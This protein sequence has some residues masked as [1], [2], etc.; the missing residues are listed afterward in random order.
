MT[1][2]R[3]HATCNSRSQLLSNKLNAEAVDT[4]NSVAGMRTAVNELRKK[5]IDISKRNRLTNTR[6]HKPRGKQIDIYEERSDEV[7]RILYVNRK[8][9]RF[10]P[11]SVDILDI[12]ETDETDE[13]IFVPSWDEQEPAAHHTDSFL[14]TKFSQE[15]LQKKLLSLYR[16][17]STMEEEQGISVLYLALGFLEWYES[18]SSDRVRHA[19]LVLLPVD[20]ERDSARG[21][22]RLAFRDQDMEP[23][24]S[25]RAMLQ[26]DFG[27]MLPDFPEVDGWLPSEY[28]NPVHGVIS[29]QPRW[30]LL[31][32]TMQ[33]GFYSYA[34]FLMYRDLEDIGEAADASLLNQIL[35]QGFEAGIDALGGTGNLDERFPDPRELGHILDADAS[36]TRIIDAARNGSNLVVQ[37][38]PGTGKS[39]TIANIIAAASKDG[40]RILFVAEKRAALDVVHARLEK[41]DLGPLCLELHSHKVS[42]KHVYAELKRTLELGRPR[43]DNEEQYQRLR[44]VRDRLNATSELL[45]TLDERSGQTPYHVMGTLSLLLSS[46]VPRPDYDIGRAADW[47]KEEF[48]ERLQIVKRLAELTHDLGSERSHLW[49]GVGRRLGPIDR[50]RLKD[51]LGDA[52]EVL[53]TLEVALKAAAAAAGIERISLVSAEE[54]VHAQVVALAERPPDVDGLIRKDV[55]V[56]HPSGLQQLFELVATCQSAKQE[57]LKRVIPGALDLSWQEERLEIAARGRSMFRF[58]SRRYRSAAARLKGASVGS[59]PKSASAR[60][61]LLDKLVEYGSAREKIRRQGALGVAVAGSRWQDEETDIARLLSSTEWICAQ[62]KRTG[63]ARAVRKQIAA[64]PSGIDLPGLAARLNQARKDWDDIWHGITVMLEL[65]PNVAFGVDEFRAVSFREFYERIEAWTAAMEGMDDWHRLITTARTASDLELVLIREALADC[66]LCPEFAPQVLEFLRAEA[67]WKRMCEAEPRLGELDG[68][69]RSAMVDEFRHLD[70]KLQQLASQEV[71]LE[72]FLR[73]P[74]GSAGQVGIVRGESGKKTRHMPIR[75]LLGSAGEA[76][77]RIKPVFLMSPLSVAQ[78]LPPGKLSFDLLLIDEASQVRPED[79]VGSIMRASS[80]V[81]VGDQKQLP[82]T[83][84]F[85]RQMQGEEGEDYPEDLASLQAAQIRDMESVLSLCEARGMPGGMLKWHYRSNHPSMIAVSNYEFY[86]DK[87]ICPPSPEEPGDQTGLSFTFVDGEYLRG[88]KRTNPKEA[89]VAAQEVLEHARKNP[90]LTL[91]VVALSVAQRDAIRNKVEFMRTEYPELEAFCKEGKEEGFFVKNLENVQG[92]ERDVIFISVG[93]GKDAE[94]YMS[95]SFGPLSAEG[96]ERRLNVLFTR[97]KRRCRVFA[98]IRHN[99]IRIDAAK[100]AGP[101]VLKRFL[102]YAEHGELDVP[103]V[104][105]DDVE[106]PFEASVARVL[107]LRGYRVT[108]QVGSAGFRIDLAVHDPDDEGRF[109]L[110]V[111]CDGARY[112]SSSWARERDRLRQ[113]VLEAKGWRFHRIW[114]TD[115]FQ[116]QAAETRKLMSAIEQ[117]RVRGPARPK[118]PASPKGKVKRAEYQPQD[119]YEFPRYK[120]SQLWLNNG[121][122]IPIPVACMESLVGFIKDIV[123]VEGPVHRDIV[124]KRLNTS[125]GNQRMGERIKERLELAINEAIGRGAIRAD[126][127][128]LFLDM[129]DRT[130]PVQVRDRSLLN[131][132]MRQPAM[133]P[134]AEIHAATLEVINRCISISPEDCAKEVSRM[135]GYTTLRKALRRHLQEHIAHA[136][137]EGRLILSEGLLRLP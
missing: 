11:A 67:V 44:E 41:C 132:Y 46:D 77:Q 38:P 80:L 113:T 60:L 45:H 51:R 135:F 68:R 61:A 81:V 78:Y 98:S 133:L 126:Q 32:N 19:P 70:E 58:L 65:D 120:E 75:R 49:R 93:Y 102:K 13:A 136:V 114:S 30:R 127:S 116:H 25:L 36:Q 94:G 1:P 5:L 47:T 33:L 122:E 87:L 110:A 56:E 115:W 39:Q 82:P 53:S 23:N 71:M 103:V 29:G 72:H 54:D 48:Q 7:Y 111:E 26:S 50:D 117:A 42:R 131:A 43:A 6:L 97:A 73:I 125:W 100:H 52:S 123:Q 134:P 86:D 14:Q 55:V 96:G 21:Q 90:A 88:T 104:T 64:L 69:D 83:S 109:I 31:P 28:F 4:N 37:G 101:R 118:K 40:K 130:E 62:A 89:T 34:K 137:T 84:F 112:H 63:T 9:M 16:D 8:K 119:S 91:G 2:A 106:S 24:L 92:D 121:W 18:A 107:Q 3:S 85:D 22:F 17:A 35:V 57:L 66:S 105:G 12:D 74:Q 95:Q 79:A 15:A 10:K 20:L 27:L 76:V 59:P 128:K 99:D 129:R 108:P 124:G